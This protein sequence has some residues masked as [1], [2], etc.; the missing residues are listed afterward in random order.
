MPQVKRNEPPSPSRR[1]PVCDQPQI[2]LQRRLNA[3]TN[4]STIYVCAR[5]EQ[6]S[7]GVNLTKVDTWVAV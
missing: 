4:G 2:K 5:W 7:V 1:C 6:C 3:S